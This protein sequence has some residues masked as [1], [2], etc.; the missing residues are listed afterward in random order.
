MTRRKR[1]C[2]ITQYYELNTREYTRRLRGGHGGAV[3]YSNGD[4][5]GLRHFCLQTDCDNS[6]RAFLWECAAFYH[7]ERCDC[8]RY[9]S[10][11]NQSSFL[12][13]TSAVEPP[14]RHFSIATVNGVYGLI[15]APPCEI[16]DAESN[17]DASR[18]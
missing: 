8:R 18:S 11:Q 15:I 5:R 13:I 14:R 16:G 10:S 1:C 9:W 4:G 6:D 12:I 2:Y 7:P 3:G 17:K